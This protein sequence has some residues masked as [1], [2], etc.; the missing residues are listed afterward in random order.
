MTDDHPFLAAT[1]REWLE[2][3][4]QEATANRH[5]IYQALD[6]ADLE[7]LRETLH[8]SPFTPE[9]L[10]YLDDLLARWGE[11]IARQQGAEKK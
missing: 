4:L 2:H 11:E 10:R 5:A 1:L 3:Q 6:R 7:A 9:Q 8:D